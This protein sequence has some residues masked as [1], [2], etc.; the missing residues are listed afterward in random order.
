MDAYQHF[1]PE[2]F[3]ATPSFIAWV[4]EPADLERNGYQSEEATFWNHWLQE[5]PEASANVE[6]ARL[7][8]MAVHLR[9]RD[10]LT[11]DVVRHDINRLVQRASET[12]QPYETPIRPLIATTNRWWMQAAAAILVVVSLGGYWY[13]RQAEQVPIAQREAAKALTEK[14][15]QTN[16]PM[17]VLLDDGSVVTL[18]AKS[19]LTYPTS[20]TGPNRPVQLVGEAFFDVERNPDKP[21]LVYTAKTVTKVLGTSFS[22]RALAGDAEVQVAVRTG[23][24]SVFTRADFDHAPPTSATA[25]VLLLPNQQARVDLA[26]N[27]IQKT[28]VDKPQTIAVPLSGPSEVTF[29]DQPV[30]D[31]LQTLAKLYEIRI[32]YD[33]AALA[34]CRITTTFAEETLPERLSSICQAIGATYRI[35]HDQVEITGKGCTAN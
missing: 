17:T 15:N 34:N 3:A 8:V 31:I 33:E 35:T 11:D 12:V 10:K 26:S 18:G 7:L 14:V 22:V 19:R 32:V 1:T 16:R 2:E 4:M 5:H 13:S 9:F 6:E 29:D 27:S 21:F 24:V 30:T 28:P 25:G 20:F 23:R